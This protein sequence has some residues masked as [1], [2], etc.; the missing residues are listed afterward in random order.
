[1][2]KEFTEQQ[3]KRFLAV[4]ERAKAKLVQS[5]FISDHIE[6]AVVSEPYPTVADG[7]IEQCKKWECAMVVVG[8]KKLS[9]AEEFVMGDVCVKLVRGLENAAVLVVKSQ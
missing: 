2:G 7:I 3:P 1:M 4:L 6:V 9:K 8:R 5:G